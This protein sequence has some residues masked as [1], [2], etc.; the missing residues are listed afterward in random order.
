MHGVGATIELG[1]CMEDC[2][3]PAREE[4]DWCDAHSCACVVC[5]EK[6]PDGE[7]FC[8]VHQERLGVRFEVDMS[9]EQLEAYDAWYGER[10]LGDPNLD[11]LFGK[12][13]YVRDVLI[14]PKVTA[15]FEKY[16]SGLRE[17]LQPDN[18]L[19]VAND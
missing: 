6:I 7:D 5:W 1:M 15:L 2:G 17:I 10:L 4:S 16:G 9:D 14:D 12:Y 19:E 18:A 13:G 11:E 8:D 3:R